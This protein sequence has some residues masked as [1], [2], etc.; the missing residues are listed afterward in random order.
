MNRV[1]RII[2]KSR[3]DVS[4]VTQFIEY[5]N[6][7]R[8]NIDWQMTK[9]WSADDQAVVSR[10]P[11]S[12]QHMTKGWSADDQG[13][14][15]SKLSWGSTPKVCTFSNWGF[16]VPPVNTTYTNV[17]TLKGSTNLMCGH[18]FRVHSL[19][20]G[21]GPGVLRTPGYWKWT[22]SASEGPFLKPNDQFELI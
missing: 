12:G 15:T 6:T 14:V 10:W 11:S 9:G 1:I 22:L 19:A 20:M 13:L 2:Q 3:R 16:E 18:S 7:R 17:M 21:C 5:P 4:C 8:N